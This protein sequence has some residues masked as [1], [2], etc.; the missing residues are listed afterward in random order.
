MKNIF[1]DCHSVQQEHLPPMMNL[2]TSS[3]LLLNILNSVY[4]ATIPASSQEAVDTKA[5]HDILISTNPE[6][7][8]RNTIIECGRIYGTELSA[9]SCLNA[10][11]Y[12]PRGLQQNAYLSEK[13]EHPR[14]E[15]AI[16]LPIATFSNDTT[17]LI[18]PTLRLDAKVGLAS[19][20]SITEAARAII[21]KCVIPQGLG[22]SAVLIGG[23]DNVR[24]IVTGPSIKPTSVVCQAAINTTP[25]SCASILDTIMTKN[26]ILKIFGRTNVPPVAVALPVT[27]NSPD[28]LCQIV[29]DTPPG[30]DKP[31]R[32]TWAAL[33]FAA[34]MIA[35]KCVRTLGKGGYATVVGGGV[36]SAKFQDLI[37]KIEDKTAVD[38]VVTS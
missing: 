22:G 28:G 35:A 3:I 16:Q 5:A 11:T 14:P 7:G 13:W 34:E 29:I 8:A 6:N 23:D 2:L 20:F 19:P 18:K 32:T 24:V 38:A 33:W 36:V 15:G 37:V 26:R 1:S 21:A 27:L 30:Q 17:C 9:P 12:A 25:R 31:L 4:A 10:I